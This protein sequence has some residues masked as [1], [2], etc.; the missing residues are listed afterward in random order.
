MKILSIID[1]DK[2]YGKERANLEVCHIMK[3]NGAELVL[4]INK[5]AD[6]SIREEASC[7][8]YHEIL[9]PRNLGGRRRWW[10]YVW[11]FLLTQFSVY[12][13]LRAEKPDFILLPTEIA[14]TYLFIPLSFTKAR[15]VFRCGDSPLV[16]RK[17]GIAARIYGWL[18]RN[19]ILKQI[20][21]VVCN[22]KFIQSQIA[23]AGRVPNQY[24]AL[25]Y[26]YPPERKINSDSAEYPFH[27]D[28]VRIGFMGR[29]VDDKGVR[30]LIQAVRQINK[31]KNRVVAYICGDTSVDRKYSD[32]LFKIA[33]ENTKFVGLV[34]DLDKFYRNVDIVAIPSVYPEPM[35][36][37][38]TE[39][40]YHKKAVIIFNIG[41]MPEIVEHKKTGYICS[42]VSVDSLAEGI[43]FY[44]DNPDIVKVHG[45]N[46][47]KSIDEL[48]LTKESYT[49]KWLKVFS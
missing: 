38:V 25:I 41:G 36:N 48:G 40:K 32:E 45:E 23:D 1:S 26:N 42:D 21:I 24:D 5:I 18:W 14:L 46:A 22:A 43:K 11:A 17:Y 3:E 35:A 6:Y 30:E 19:L 28:V 20:D 37:V 4:L 15:K 10:M 49:E 13:I 31:D 7:Y 33:D 16:F 39:A 29:I 8:Q 47:Y 9:F 2:A 27:D 12:R 44:L 34:R